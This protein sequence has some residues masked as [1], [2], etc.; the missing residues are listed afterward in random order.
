MSTYDPYSLANDPSVPIPTQHLVS[1][2]QGTQA[3]DA[4]QNGSCSMCGRTTPEAD[5]SCRVKMTTPKQPR[6][7][8]IPLM[9]VLTKGDELF[10]NPKSREQ[11]HWKNHDRIVFI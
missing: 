10:L 11:N 9:S 1:R 2:P 5:K 6:W 4:A 3:R 8:M 7:I